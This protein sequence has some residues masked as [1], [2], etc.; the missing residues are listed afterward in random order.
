MELVLWHAAL[1]ASFATLRKRPL[2]SFTQL[3]WQMFLPYLRRIRRRKTV[4][5]SVG[6]II[7]GGLVPTDTESAAT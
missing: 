5:V 6:G 4:P 7:Q 1:A 2:F 3:L